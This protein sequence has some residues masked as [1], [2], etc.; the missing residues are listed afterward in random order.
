MDVLKMSFEKITYRD[1]GRSAFPTLNRPNNGNMF[2]ENR[3]SKIRAGINAD[4]RE[5]RKL[6]VA[7]TGTGVWFLCVGGCAR[8]DPVRRCSADAA[9]MREH[10]STENTGERV[11]QW[12][13]SGLLRRLQMLCDITGGEARKLA[14]ALSEGRA[15]DLTQLGR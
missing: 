8:R 6:R 10:R 3:Y 13:R 12:F 9:N 11:R 5:T 4:R 7:I 15:P 2:T 14:V 1:G